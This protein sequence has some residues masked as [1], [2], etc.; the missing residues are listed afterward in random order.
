MSGTQAE[1]HWAHRYN[2]Y[3][4]LAETPEKLGDLIEP[5]R[6]EWRSTN[7]VPDWCGVDLLRGWA[8][9]LTREDRFSGGGTLGKE[10]DSVL[11]AIRHHRAATGADR[12]PPRVSD[13]VVLPSNFS[14]RPKQHRDSDFLASKQ[15]RLWEEHVAPINQF[16]DQVKVEVAELRALAGESERP[17]VVPYVDPDSGG[18]RAKVLFLMESPAGPA[19]LGSG[20]LSADND[21]ETAKNVWRAYEASGLPRTFGLHWNAVPWYVGDGKKNKGVTPT[22]VEQGRAY[23]D[24]LLD[25]A[26]EISV[27]L[28]L[29]RPAQS[30]I[31]A[32][33]R[34]LNARDI[35]VISAPHPSPIS[36]GV[37]KGES[38][39]QVN[40]AVALAHRLASGV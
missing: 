30:S 12:P 7:R 34:D 28:A 38:L 11:D 9:Y 22:D 21:D 25:L 18:V 17:V 26:P 20:M 37:T 3:Q 19:A 16:V 24:Q 33:E 39:R 2:G 10:W 1:I 23:L 35:Q 13:R 6:R 36:A 40:D 15:A 14:T 31:A 5:A 8:F 29:G 32:A 27:V 4:R